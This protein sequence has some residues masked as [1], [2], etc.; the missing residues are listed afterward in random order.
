MEERMRP[1]NTLMRPKQWGRQQGGR[2]IG[3][4]CQLGIRLLKYVRQKHFGCTRWHSTQRSQRQS[5]PRAR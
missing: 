5:G 2:L 1:S 4:P 3:L